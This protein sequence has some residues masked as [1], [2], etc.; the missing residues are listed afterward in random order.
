MLTIRN[1]FEGANIIIDGLDEAAKTASVRQDIRDSGEWWFFWRFRASS[2]IDATYRFVFTDGGIVSRFGPAIKKG[3]ED[4]H[5][6][7]EV[8]RSHTEFEYTFKANEEVDFSF[9]IPYLSEDFDKF[10]KEKGLEPKHLCTTE[11]GRENFYYRIGNPE[12]DLLVFTCRHHAC[13]AEAEFVLEGLLTQII[14]SNSCLK[15]MFDILIVPFMDLDGVQDG[16]QGKSRLPHDHNRDYIDEPIYASVRA[17]YQLT[18]GKKIANALDLHC[19][20]RW[21]GSHNYVSITGNPSPRYEQERIFSTLL[22][23]NAKDCTIPYDP[24]NDLLFG[25][26]WNCVP[27]QPNSTNWF[28]RKG[29]KLAFTFEIPFFGERE[30]PYGQDELRDFG[31]CV[32]VALEEYVKL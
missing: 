15:E 11:R 18:E 30:I 23:K 7:P 20:A 5:F 25:M 27:N 29:A 10:A 6:E 16:D 31:K 32:A 8:F 12:K 19:P 24:K 17:L 9:C 1:D 28:T 13:E 26:G 4:W 21:G 14:E 22:V 2:D 3:E